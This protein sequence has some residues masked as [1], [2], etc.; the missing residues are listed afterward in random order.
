MIKRIKNKHLLSS[1]TNDVSKNPIRVLY[2]KVGQ[3]S[4]VKI[5]SDVYK[6]KKAIIERNLDI[7]PYEKIF[8]ICHS[9][10]SIQICFL[11]YFYHLKEY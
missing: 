11:I 9:K 5:I 1:K 6:L 7:I 3:P 4:E 2:K 10:K 8:I